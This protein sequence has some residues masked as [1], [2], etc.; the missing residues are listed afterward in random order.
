MINT[1][2]D[3]SLII[4]S[5]ISS[6][7]VSTY[8]KEIL[9]LVFILLDN[10]SFTQNQTYPR[11]SHPNPDKRKDAYFTLVAILLSLRTTL[12][13]EVRAVD[14]FCNQYSNIYDVINSDFDELV[15]VIKCAGMPNKKAKTIIN[16]SRYIIDNFNGDINLINNGNIEY[17]RNELFK[18][19]GLGE[20]SVDCMLEL[21]FDLPSIVIDTNVF[22][23]IS[24]IYF[25]D[26]DMSFNNKFH[27][28]KIKNYIE[29][30][31][32][33]DFRIYQIIHT[34]ILL[35][36]KYVCKSKPNCNDCIVKEKCGFFRKNNNNFQLTLF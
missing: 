8:E 33:K 23:V 3:A 27:I 19:S 17:T 25:P 2:N 30:S 18:I 24:R 20:K 16:V 35:H 7:D 28:L 31:V 1:D 15:N 13:N 29:S 32:I 6:K 36:G 10:Y 34:I 4:E 12:E 26:E 14:N 21:A 11:P 9:D 22:R 5:R